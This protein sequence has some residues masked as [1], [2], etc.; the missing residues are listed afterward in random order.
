VRRREES[1]L[2]TQLQVIWDTSRSSR[3]DFCFASP[4]GEEDE[5]MRNNHVTTKGKTTSSER[6]KNKKKV[7]A[8]RAK[9]LKD[10]PSHR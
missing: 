8:A 9:Q 10:L 7:L 1:F 2:V 6:L 5:I 3:R 4:G